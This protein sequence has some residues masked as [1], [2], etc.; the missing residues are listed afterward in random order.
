MKVTAFFEK[1]FT[2]CVPLLIVLVVNI[3][4]S[5]NYSLLSSGY[6]PMSTWCNMQ[7]KLERR[8]HLLET[9]SDK[10]DGDSHM[11]K[12]EFRL[13]VP[14]L[15]KLL[16]IDTKPKLYALQVAAGLLFFFLLNGLALQLCRS[17]PIAFLFCMAFGFIYPGYS[18]I[19]E[20]EGFFDSFGYL[21]LLIAMLDLPVVLIAAAMF[22]AFFNDE[23]TIVASSLI[24]FWWQYKATAERGK[25]FFLP[26]KQTISIVVAFAVY[27]FCRW[28]LIAHMGF[29]NQFGGT[30]A[31]VFAST[32]KYAGLGFWQAFEGFW[33]LVL[34]ALAALYEQK[35][36]FIG[37]LLIAINGLIYL[38]GLTVLDVTKSIAYLFPTIIIALYLVKDRIEAKEFR[39]YMACTLIFCFFYPSYYY[40]AGAEPKPYYPIYLRVMKNM[41]HKE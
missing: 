40:I 13:T 32:M 4:S 15:A 37:L 11:A 2:W 38:A 19:A 21:F 18:F 7:E 26:A 29:K 22:F 25:N 6:K 1:H 23:R 3:F 14:L 28:Y 24:V 31:S 27:C 35:K 20:T 39:K 10:Y 12:S 30:G 5:P 9:V 34:L 17:K 8:N 41:T 36:Y 33:L 16:F